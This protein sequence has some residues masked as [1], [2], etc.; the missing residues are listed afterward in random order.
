L[1]FG[2]VRSNVSRSV[3]LVTG[4]DTVGLYRMDILRMFMFADMKVMLVHVSVCCYACNVVMWRRS[5]IAYNE[6]VTV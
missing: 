6:Y 2:T 4:L 5:V 3:E 1:L